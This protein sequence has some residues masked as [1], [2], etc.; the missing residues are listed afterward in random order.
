M[1][2]VTRP[3]PP[4]DPHS[5]RD[6]GHGDADRHAALLEGGGDE[7]AEGERRHHAQREGEER[8]GPGQHRVHLPPGSAR[9]AGS[10]AAAAARGGVGEPLRR[11]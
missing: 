2:D 5:Q 6:P 11:S 7:A 4:P 3:A 1:P 8:V 9:R 10:R